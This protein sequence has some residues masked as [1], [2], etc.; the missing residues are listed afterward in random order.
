M[1]ASGLRPGKEEGVTVSKNVIIKHS[2]THRHRN[3]ETVG[4][5]TLFDKFTRKTQILFFKNITK[6]NDNLEK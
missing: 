3:F 6:F 2:H 1:T 5:S 4:S